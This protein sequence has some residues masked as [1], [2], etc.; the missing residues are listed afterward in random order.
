MRVAEGHRFVT[1]C[2]FIVWKVNV[3]LDIGVRLT[4]PLTLVSG[5]MLINVVLGNDVAYFYY[6][7]ARVDS[8]VPSETCTLLIVCVCRVFACSWLRM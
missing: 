2:L 4:T 8:G 3:V 7:R 1:P 6:T 5:I